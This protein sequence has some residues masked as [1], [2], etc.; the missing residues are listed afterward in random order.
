M[1]ISIDKFY[2]T[3]FYNRCLESL[4]N[5]NIEFNEYISTTNGYKWYIDIP[6]APLML[7]YEVCQKD[8]M[9]YLVTKVKTLN[10]ADTWKYYRYEESKGKFIDKYTKNDF[11]TD[12]EGKEACLFKVSSKKQLEELSKVENTKIWYLGKYFNGRYRLALTTG[13]GIRL[14][15]PFEDVLLEKKS[16]QSVTKFELDVNYKVLRNKEKLVKFSGTPYYQS[17][18]YNIPMYYQEK[19]KPKYITI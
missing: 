3:K 2:S 19:D 11:M 9:R 6:Q 17:G 4:K 14:Y 1:L 18:S 10:Y 15:I 13:A 16:E 7:D 5:N 8:E 12:V